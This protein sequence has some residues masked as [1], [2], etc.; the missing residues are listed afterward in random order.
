MRERERKREK[1]ESIRTTAIE[2]SEKIDRKRME[3]GGVIGGL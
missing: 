2:I 1:K 3:I